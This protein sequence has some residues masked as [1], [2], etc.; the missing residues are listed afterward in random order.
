MF[1]NLEPKNGQTP[2]DPANS[3]K[4]R[5]NPPQL[6][7]I[8]DTGP[9]DSG[10]PGEPEDIFAGSSEISAV[11]PP[12]RKKPEI[13]QP[14]REDAHRE[15]GELVEDGRKMQKIFILLLVLLAASL[16]IIGGYW[17]LSTFFAQSDQAPFSEQ[18]NGFTVEPEAEEEQPPAEDPKEEEGS[19]QEPDLNEEVPEQEAAPSEP[20]TSGEEADSD[21]DGLSDREE[22]ILGTSPYEVDTD[23]DG[24][25][26]REE[27]KIYQTNPL[28]PDSDND[29]YK[30]GE[31]VKAN[32]NPL[33]EGRLFEL[34]Q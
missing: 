17:A 29:G 18:D 5:E 13:L 25:F 10:K 31:E 6:E 20:E 9:A 3:G 22:Q 15:G 1:D 34:E 7:R 26:D 27:V 21:R 16:L 24:L 11:N 23:Q 28:E 12:D 33:G 32:Y 30:D 4:N 19:E 14:V 2:P 8:P